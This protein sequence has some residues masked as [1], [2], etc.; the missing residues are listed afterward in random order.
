MV[1]QRTTWYLKYDP[2]PEMR[3]EPPSDDPQTRLKLSDEL[4]RSIWNIILSDEEFDFEFPKSRLL[5]R[6]TLEPPYSRGWA[7]NLSA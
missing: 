1:L 7:K 2:F 3:D 4:Q 6:V 5:T